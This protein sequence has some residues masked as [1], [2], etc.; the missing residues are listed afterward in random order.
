MVLKNSSIACYRLL[1]FLGLGSA[2][3]AAPRLALTQTA[4]SVSVVPG[5]NGPAQ[6][7]DA[8]NI[9]DGSL[10]LQLTSSVGWLAATLGPSHKCAT[11]KGLCVPVQI[12]LQTA[13]LAKGTFTG[14]ITISDP[15]ALD[16]PQVVTVTVQVGG[17]V[18]DSLEF[19]VPP[20]GSASSQFITGSP[21]KDTVTPAS[22][23]LSLAVEGGGTFKFNVPYQL[24]VTGTAATGDSNASVALSGSNFAPDN[25]TISVVMHVTTLP[26]AATS[27]TAVMLKG[28]QGAI[29][30]TATLAITNGGQGTLTVS[31]VTAAVTN[32]SGW[33]TATLATNGAS[34]A[35]TAD[36]TS[37]MP[38][39]YQG[40]VTIASNAANSSVVIP[41]QFL[42]EA[43]MA[44]FAFAGGAVNNGTFASGEPLAQGDI[45]AVFGDQFTLQDLAYPSGVPLTTNLNGTQ[46]LV[47]DVPAPLYFISGGQID[48]EVPFEVPAGNATVSVV[49]NGQQGNKIYVKIASSAPRFILLTGGPYAV[50]NTP[51]TPPA[52]T[53]NPDHPVKAGDVIVVYTIGLGQTSPAVSTGA[54]APGKP[55]ALVNS[56]QAC[57]GG[58]TPFDKM[59]CV[60]PDFA[61]LSPGFVGL[62]QVNVKIPVLPSGDA[63]FFFTV[64]TV[65]SNN[66]KLTVH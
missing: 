24:K 53:G 65:P 5:S 19:F 57:F 32:G 17:D 59:V 23:W 45:G 21:V 39:T 46:V 63:S 60:K 11:L 41:V 36:P 37:L 4:F 10:S 3:T 9:G 56:V 61:G 12:A 8:A 52:V 2:L 27:A 54:A 29:K 6:T 34:V 33:L 51:D 40:T 31:G 16:A 62:Y 28:V 66:V 49:R 35:I 42:V 58:D 43:Q 48:F 64:G 15:A 44:P 7:L 13:S 20:G 47:N 50:I 26:I 14:S 38:D 18:P 25:K 30:Q 55:L 22:P 1:L